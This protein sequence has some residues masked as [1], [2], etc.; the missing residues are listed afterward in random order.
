MPRFEGWFPPR[1]VFVIQSIVSTFPASEPRVRA[2]VPFA[3]VLN[4]ARPTGSV[5][6]RVRFDWR[7]G[8]AHLEDE[9]WAP[10]R[11]AGTGCIA[12]DGSVPMCGGRPFASGWH[13]CDR[14]EV[15]VDAKRPW[16][17]LVCD[18]TEGAVRTVRVVNFCVGV[19]PHGR[20]PSDVFT[21]PALRAVS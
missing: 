13:A 5:H 19:H 12:V 3:S 6:H 14:Q 8:L 21:N 15:L 10:W 4:N 18:T 16:G 7:D 17:R 20:V 1:P 9:C 11:L 2:L